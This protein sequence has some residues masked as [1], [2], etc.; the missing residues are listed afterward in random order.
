M[1]SI[2]FLLYHLLFEY[3]YLWENQWHELSTVLTCYL[4][5]IWI[6]IKSTSSFVLPYNSTVSNSSIT[7]SLWICKSTKYNGHFQFFLYHALLDSLEEEASKGE[8]MEKSTG[9]EIKRYI[10]GLQIDFHNFIISN[11][12]H[13][14]LVLH[15]IIRNKIIAS[16][17]L[18]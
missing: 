14:S 15:S 5:S 8:D 4:N 7:Y 2:R 17:Y 16:I 10:L 13:K 18:Y 11:S 9:G 6:W 12:I 1:V 3:Y